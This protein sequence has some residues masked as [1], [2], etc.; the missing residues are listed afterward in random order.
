MYI[1]P[2]GH[3]LRGGLPW[4]WEAFWAL[5]FTAA[6]HQSRKLNAMH[7]S[8]DG[9][10]ETS[11]ISNSFWNKPIITDCSWR[12]AILLQGIQGYWIFMM[13][14]IEI[15]HYCIWFQG[16]IF[17]VYNLV[18]FRVSCSPRLLGFQVFQAFGTQS[19]PRF[20]ASIEVFTDELL[21]GL[22]ISHRF[23]ESIWAF[24]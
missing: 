11:P 23:L 1:L 3:C 15:L 9:G 21:L 6:W 5:P 22:V 18:R 2:A 19:S 16:L 10:T 24:D 13:L 17:Q 8:A 4:W 14:S 20:Q 7:F 12:I